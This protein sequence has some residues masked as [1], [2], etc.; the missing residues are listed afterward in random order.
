MRRKQRTSNGFEVD[1]ALYSNVISVITKKDPQS[2]IPTTFGPALER[3]SP[4]PF[5]T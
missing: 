5:L 3:L 4:L 2:T 1:E